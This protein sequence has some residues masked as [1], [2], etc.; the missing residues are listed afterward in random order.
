MDQELAKQHLAWNGT[1]SSGRKHIERQRQII[2]QHILEGVDAYD[3][4]ELLALLEQSQVLHERHHDR[5]RQ[6]LGLA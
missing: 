4:E 2:E 6:E 5:L 1:L 3:A